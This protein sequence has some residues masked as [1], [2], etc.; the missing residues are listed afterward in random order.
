[1]CE[2]RGLEGALDITAFGGWRAYLASLGA[3]PR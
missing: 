2:P 1:M 3:A